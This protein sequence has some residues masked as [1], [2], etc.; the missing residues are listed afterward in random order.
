MRKSLLLLLALLPAA[1]VFANS[2]I[3][4]ESQGSGSGTYYETGSGGWVGESSANAVNGDQRYSNASDAAAHYTFSNLAAGNY[5]AYATYSVNQN[6][7]SSATYTINGGGAVTID[8]V[9]TGN[10]LSIK[11]TS[12]ASRTIQ[13]ALI[14]QA[15]SVGAGGSVTVAA[16]N[17]GSGYLIADSV[18]LEKVRDDV[19]AVHL[20]YPQS[21]GNRGS[22]SFT[23]TAGWSTYGDA[24][25]TQT[26]GGV[27]GYYYGGPGESADYTFGGLDDGYYRLSACWTPSS[28]RPEGALNMVNGLVVGTADQ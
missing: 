13:T 22:N 16:R 20:V 15:V 24:S 4:I 27:S 7:T 19:K 3:T 1:A 6:R 8:Q 9:Q 17:T 18:T 12:A 5:V 2:P 28:N 11:D 23:K 10:W 14:N 26:L 25:I 21:T